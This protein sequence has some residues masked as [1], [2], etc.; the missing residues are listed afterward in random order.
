MLHWNDGS[1][2]IDVQFTLNVSIIL[3]TKTFHHHKHISVFFKA[4]W[5]SLGALNCMKIATALLNK[6][7]SVQ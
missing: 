1:F 7:D 6:H 2:E 5:T 4:I 3:Q